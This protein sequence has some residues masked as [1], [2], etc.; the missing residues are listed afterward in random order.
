MS[1]RVSDGIFLETIDGE[2]IVLDGAGN[3][4]LTL[5]ETGAE[6]L[7]TISEEGDLDQITT[8]LVAGWDVEADHARAFAREFV[9]DLL[10]RG[11]IEPGT[12]E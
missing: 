10:E 9:D 1:W 12:H 7:R 2:M 8:R 4:Y 5:N 11:I 3:T 6:I